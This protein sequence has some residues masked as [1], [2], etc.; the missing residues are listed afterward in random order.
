M[1]KYELLIMHRRSI[2]NWGDSAEFGTWS[3][4]RV[5][6]EYPGTMAPGDS[7]GPLSFRCHATH[8]YRD[9]MTADRRY[10]SFMFRLREI[11]YYE[12][13]FL[14]KIWSLSLNLCGNHNHLRSRL[15]ELFNCQ[16]QHHTRQA[17]EVRPDLRSPYMKTY[18]K[19]RRL[20]HN[21]CTIWKS[22]ITCE[23]G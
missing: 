6:H 1:A 22:K 7:Q 9:T 3:P 10:W 15:K 2:L 20:L 16:W 21:S 17:C 5:S 19:T 14:L 11:K 8:R 18:M 12:T 23:E 13:N 4:L